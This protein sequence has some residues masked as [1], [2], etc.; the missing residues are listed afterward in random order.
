MA[1]DRKE[2]YHISFYEYGE[3]YY[4]SSEG[5]RF[6][7]GRRPL[8]NVRYTPPEERG[9]AVL[10]VVVWPE[11]FSY[12]HT[13]EEDRIRKDFDF[14]EEGLDEAASWLERVREEEKERFSP[15][16]AR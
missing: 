8:E 3:A 5:M 10:E 12:A 15:Q 13:A 2:L 4:G 6:R 14:S 1:I 16:D 7:I 11:P 9:E